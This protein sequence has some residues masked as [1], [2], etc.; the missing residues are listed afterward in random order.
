MRERATAYREYGDAGFLVILPE[1]H[2]LLIS[3]RASYAYQRLKD[4]L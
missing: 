3:I 1:I 2:D 4:D